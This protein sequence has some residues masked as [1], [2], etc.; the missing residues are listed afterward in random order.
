MPN[1]KPDSKPP[2]LGRKI[3][4]FRNRGSVT[5]IDFDGEH[6]RVV[7]AAQRGA[8]PKITRLASPAFDAAKGKTDAAA[9]GRALRKAL[10]E[11]RLKPKEAIF[12]LPRGQVVLRPL[13]VPMVQDVRELSAVVNFQISKDLPFRVE[14]AA[15]DF[16]VLRQLEAAPAQPDPEQTPA[17]TPETGEPAAETAQARL[18]VFVG[19]VRSEIVQFHEA[20]AK[21]AGLKLAG[22]AL[23]STGIARVIADCYPAPPDGAVAV[24]SVRRDDISIEIIEANGLVFSRV[25]AI[26]AISSIGQE[27]HEGK[28]ALSRET[29]LSR[30]GVEVVRSL[31]G[32]E[33]MMGHK[34]VRKMLVSG[35]TGLE[36]EITTLLASRAAFPVEQLDPLAC[37]NGLKA[38]PAEASACFA[39]IG[40]AFAALQPA[41][42]PLDFANPKRPP[43]HRDLRRVKILGAAVAG[44]ALLITLFGVRANM[45]QKR[46]AIRDQVHLLHE[47]AKEKQKIYRRL[48]L[49]S[50]AVSSWMRQDQNWL[51]HLAYLSGLL[52]GAEQIYVSAI[53]T[54]RQQVIRMA[55]H[56][57]SG[58]VLSELDKKLR[59]AGYEV[60]PISITPANDK[61]GYNF[62][63]TVELGIPDEMKPDLDKIE[64]P[65]RPADDTNPRAAAARSSSG[66]LP[67]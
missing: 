11:C 48:I 57:K 62:R 54:T 64:P 3:S 39:A 28:P 16:K 61:Y 37:L 7:Q 45:I 34:P 27:E 29:F 43:V 46:E 17:E 31:H 59:A 6:V 25:A 67:S 18:E 32:Y 51:D 58:E 8:A 1:R 20:A 26:P 47:D 35:A 66:G 56:A 65:P 40:L 63:T 14:D 22:L 60:R 50:R 44:L 41:G 19:A 5:V 12:A 42:L 21:A 13:Q 4:R 33:G 15:V 55:V 24:I 2:Q 52:P 9:F 49:Q 10:D 36:P 38:D 23:R 30:L 53:T